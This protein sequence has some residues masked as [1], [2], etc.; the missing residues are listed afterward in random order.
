MVMAGVGWVRLRLNEI[1]RQNCGK[2]LKGLAIAL[3][4]AART[5]QTP[6]IPF[7]MQCNGSIS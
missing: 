4:R 1:G 2:S 5:R 6:I 7:S 3:L